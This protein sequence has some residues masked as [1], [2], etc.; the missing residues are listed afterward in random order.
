M[1]A[2][3][4]VVGRCGVETFV[5]VARVNNNDINLAVQTEKNENSV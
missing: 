4:E 1:I 2:V 5:E 3:I